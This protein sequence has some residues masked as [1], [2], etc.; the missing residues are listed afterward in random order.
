MIT[1]KTQYALRAIYEL[2]R[3][4][5]EGPIWSKVRKSVT[6]IFDKTTIQGLIDEQK[7]GEAKT[8]GGGAPT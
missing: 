1:Q 4:R 3:H 6:D 2:A 5:G 7:S 8:P